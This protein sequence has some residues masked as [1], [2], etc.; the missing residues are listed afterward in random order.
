MVAFTGRCSGDKMLTVGLVI[1]VW[2]STALAS[3]PSHS[4]L[5]CSFLYK[6][7]FGFITALT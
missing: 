3:A 1:L 4:W 5:I 6:L 2:V 7:E